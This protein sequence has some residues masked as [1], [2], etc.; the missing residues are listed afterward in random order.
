MAPPLDP[1]A[2]PF[3]DLNLSIGEMPWRLKQDGLNAHSANSIMS[4]GDTAPAYVQIPA[5]HLG[6]IFWYH[7]RRVAH[8]GDRPPRLVSIQEAIEIYT[9][10]KSTDHLMI[11]LFALERPNPKYG[12]LVYG[13]E[14]SEQTEGGILGPVEPGELP[15]IWREG[16]GYVLIVAVYNFRYERSNDIPVCFRRCRELRPQCST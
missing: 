15:M 8:I 13:L 16:M 11:S 6:A 12:E 2:I 14:P 5:S 7:R 4:N 3:G 1:S 10:R 9:S